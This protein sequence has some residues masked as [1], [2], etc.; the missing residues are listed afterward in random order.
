MV[1][2][3]VLVSGPDILLHPEVVLGSFVPLQPVVLT[4]VRVAPA[5]AVVTVAVND[6]PATWVRSGDWLR[7]Q[8]QVVVAALLASSGRYVVV[9][10]LKFC[11][12]IKQLK[13]FL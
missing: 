4:L 7:F 8:V 10:Y 13:K 12:K 5:V 11:F 9:D 1:I 6:V 2:H 3:R